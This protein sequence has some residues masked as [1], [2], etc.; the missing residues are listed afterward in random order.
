LYAKPAPAVT[1]I[2]THK[3]YSGSPRQIPAGQRPVFEEAA[4]NFMHREQ[5]RTAAGFTLLDPAG[6]GAGAGPRMLPPL[7]PA[8]QVP[9]PPRPHVQTA[10]P[11][12]QHG[13]NTTSG[14]G[15]VNQQCPVYLLSEEDV[16]AIRSMLPNPTAVSDQFIRT[17]P[18][19][20][21]LALNGPP[22]SQGPSA[23]NAQPDNSHK[24]NSDLESRM[25]ANMEKLR[26]NPVKY[27]EADDDR[28]ELLH[29]VRVAGGIGGGS[30]KVWSFVRETHGLESVVPIVCYDMETVAADGSRF[31]TQPPKTSL[32]SCTAAATSATTPSVRKESP[33]RMRR[34]ALMLGTP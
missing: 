30:Q 27:A 16:P 17:Q 12:A 5:Q 3:Q 14:T 8:G 6:G 2:Y 33:S 19:H 9:V 11:T 28:M 25:A 29:P 31:T 7:R 22:A 1:C 26:T 18:M 32:S 23:D 21:L 13:A 34:T 24:K 15:P 20:I 4:R 10:R